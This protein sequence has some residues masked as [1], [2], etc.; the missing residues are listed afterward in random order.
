M[1]E[2]ERSA[3]RLIFREEV[4]SAVYASEQRIGEQVDTGLG[5][6]NERL[7]TL[8][9]SLGSLSEQ[10]ETGLG[11]MNE[12]ITHLESMV[13]QMAEH[14][15]LLRAGHRELKGDLLDVKTELGQIESVLNEV[16]IKINDIE[17][18]QYSLETKVEENI[19]GI[20]RDVQRMF[21]NLQTFTK[22]FNAIVKNTHA[23]LDLHENTPIGET[24]PGSAA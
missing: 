3:L 11:G 10:L 19:K 7:D 13:T 23:R 24:H 14:L 18:S 9:T 21:A 8:G 15:K 6:M 20:W 2:E 22:E 16:S 12:R 5:G 17:R 1:T 4:N